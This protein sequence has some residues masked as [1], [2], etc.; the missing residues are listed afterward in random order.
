MAS[1]AWLSDV[2]RRNAT[3]PAPTPAAQKQRDHLLQSLQVREPACLTSH[4]H[5][6]E[7]DAELVRP[8][9][10]QCA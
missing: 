5:L 10:A 8:S 6:H 9:H 2:L 3:A 4:E 1:P 7:S